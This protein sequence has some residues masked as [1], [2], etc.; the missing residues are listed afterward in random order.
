MTFDTISSTPQVFEQSLFL[1][2][3]EAEGSTETYL[4]LSSLCLIIF[5]SVGSTVS[6]LDIWHQLA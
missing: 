6:A 2:Y 3:S 4:I 1:F 5:F